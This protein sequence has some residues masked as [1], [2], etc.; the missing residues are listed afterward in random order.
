MGILSRCSEIIKSN[1]NDLLDRAE[2]PAK[3]VDQMLRDALEDRAEAKQKLGTVIANEETAESRMLESKKKLDRY[4]MAIQNAVKAGKDE[5]AKQLIADKQREQSRFDA[6][7]EAYQSAH[8]DAEA[9]RAE[10]AKL[11]NMIQDLEAKADRIKAKTASAKSRESINKAVSGA[12]N[13]SSLEAFDRMEA[14]A[15]KRLAAAKA[16]ASLDAS[17]DP[18]AG[19]LSKYGSGSPSSVEDELAR[20]KAEMGMS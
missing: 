7:N 1:I 17:S 3:L 12:S 13:P 10:W 14:K 2:D 20:M 19:L 8:E 16:V 6:L 11:T 5:D 18:S 15:D 9:A 4:P